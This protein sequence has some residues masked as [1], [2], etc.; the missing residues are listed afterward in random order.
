M[1]ISLRLASTSLVG[2]LLLTA[3]CGSP[4]PAPPITAGGSSA[5]VPST[6]PPSS[7]TPAAPSTAPSGSASA[8]VVVGPA[9]ADLRQ[10]DWAATPFP[11]DFCDVPGLVRQ[12]SSEEVRE[13]S[14]TWGRVHLNQYGHMAYGDVDGDGRDEAAMPVSCDNGGGTASGQ[15]VFGYVV[16]GRSPAG[17]VALGSLTPR[18][19]PSGVAATRMGGVVLTS[20]RATVTEHWYRP[21]DATCCPRGRATTVWTFEGDHVSPGSP[22]ITS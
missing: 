8:G 3:G 13:N 14:R 20:R 11:G 9:P 6:P 12:G 22:S 1:A 15:L 16:F 19:Q 4:A 21:E 7:A 10:V 5:P 17:L 18:Q 2:L